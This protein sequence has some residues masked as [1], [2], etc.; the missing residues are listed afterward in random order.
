MTRVHTPRQPQPPTRIPT[1]VATQLQH[2]A[3]GALM[4][5]IVTLLERRMR[6]AFDR[7]R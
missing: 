4:S 2:A 5:I 6:K 7:Q 1:R 3:L